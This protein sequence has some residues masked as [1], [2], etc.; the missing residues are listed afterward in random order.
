MRYVTI[1]ESPRER[2]RMFVP[3]ELELQLEKVP[4]Q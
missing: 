2:L 3:A 1:T 4:V